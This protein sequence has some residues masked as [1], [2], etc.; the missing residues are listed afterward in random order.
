MTTTFRRP[1]FAVLP[2]HV[3]GVL[4]HLAAPSESPRRSGASC[5]GAA[6]STLLLLHARKGRE[7]E[8]DDRQVPQGESGK[9]G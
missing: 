3:P 1:S 5:L 2:R 4:R 9:S 8:G 7:E 6:T